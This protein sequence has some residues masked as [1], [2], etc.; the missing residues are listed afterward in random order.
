MKG[1]MKLSDEKEIHKLFLR[2]GLTLST[3]ESCTGGRIASKITALPGSSEYFKGSIV[4]YSNEVK[5][6]L[7][8]VSRQILDEFGAV[9]EE[10][11]VE[12]VKGAMK[13]LKTDC[14]VAT[15]GVAGPGGG[16]AEKPVG[17]VWIAAAYREK[18]FTMRQEGDSGRLLNMDRAANNALSLLLDVIE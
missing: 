9:S 4:A 11:V 14:A 2:K 5:E 7:L 12:M 17:T 15:S 1:D 13:T 18:I 8:N 3:A 16:T 6:S 10:T